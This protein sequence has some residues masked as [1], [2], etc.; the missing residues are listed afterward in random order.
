MDNFK[1]RPKIIRLRTVQDRTG[2]SRSTIYAWIDEGKFPKQIKIGGRSTG[3]VEEDID[4]WIGECIK[5][6]QAKEIEIVI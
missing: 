2:L 4:N 6:S 3:W 1:Y 5:Q